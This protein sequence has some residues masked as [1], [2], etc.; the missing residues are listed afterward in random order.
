MGSKDRGYLREGMAADIVVYDFE[1]LTSVPEHDTVVAHDMPANEWRR[2]QRAE[3]Y[4]WTLVN[5]EV[6][7]ENGECTGATPGALL[8]GG[9]APT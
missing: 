8:R 2:V 5:G 7:F 6:T 1:N 9:R 4:R 3:G